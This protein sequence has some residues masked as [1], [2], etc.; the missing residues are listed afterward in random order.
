M[1]LQ[2]PLVPLSLVAGATWGC[3]AIVLDGSTTQGDGY[4]QWKDPRQLVAAVASGSLVGLAVTA[5]F[6]RLLTRCRRP[7]D[8]ALPLIT[9]PFAYVLFGTLI[10]ATRMVLPASNTP[11]SWSVTDHLF[12]V[13]T[14][15]LFYGMCSLAMPVLYTLALTTQW[16]VRDQL[17]RWS[18]R[19]G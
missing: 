9:L 19:P 14:T 8:L 1:C 12:V 17:R 7:W 4:I 10:W 15:Y 18:G 5:V 3:A 2:R 11:P 16:L 13:T 6:E